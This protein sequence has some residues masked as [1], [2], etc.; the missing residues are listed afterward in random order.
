MGVSLLLVQHLP[1]QKTK[2]SKSS[3]RPSYPSPQCSPNEDLKTTAYIPTRQQRK[4][5]LSEQQVLF[6]SIKLLPCALARSL[7][8]TEPMLNTQPNL[9]Q[10][11]APKLMVA[12]Q[13]KADQVAAVG[14][15]QS[16]D[17]SSGSVRNQSDCHQE[18]SKY[19]NQ[20]LNVQP[21]D[22]PKLAPESAL[23]PTRP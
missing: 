22:C 11:T 12:P 19:H 3:S 1:L 17:R 9:H 20:K 6:I 13:L 23:R 7:R 21:L 15:N 16:L 14:P 5:H 2:T 8:Q 4:S 18:P 10:H